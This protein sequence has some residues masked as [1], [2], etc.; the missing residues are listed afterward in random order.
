MFYGCDLKEDVPRIMRH[1]QKMVMLKA[2]TMI[3]CEIEH[4]AKREDRQ[5]LDKVYYNRIVKN[6][7]HS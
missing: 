7:S 1:K 3:L 4:F 2:V 5:E 6:L